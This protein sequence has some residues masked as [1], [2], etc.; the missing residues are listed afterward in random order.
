MIDKAIIVSQKLP[1]YAGE[2]LGFPT[3]CAPEKNLEDD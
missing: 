2:Y 3:F 1:I